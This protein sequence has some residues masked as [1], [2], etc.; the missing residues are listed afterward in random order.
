MQSLDVTSQISARLPSQF[1]ATFLFFSFAKNMEC[2]MQSTS[3][4]TRLVIIIRIIP[5]SATRKCSTPRVWGL[6]RGCWRGGACPGPSLALLTGVHCAA[7]HYYLLRQY[8]LL[9]QSPSPPEVAAIPKTKVMGSATRVYL[10]NYGTSTLS[11]GKRNAL[12]QEKGYFVVHNI[13]QMIRES[14]H[15]LLIDC[16]G[17]DAFHVSIK[18]LY[19]H[20]IH[21]LL[22]LLISRWFQEARI[23]YEF[24][25]RHALLTMH[26]WFLHKRLLS[27]QVDSHLALLVQVHRSSISG[28]QSFF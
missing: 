15:M 25:P 26:V 18:N 2:N 27:D 3:R 19:L 21:A 8:H 11:E 24:R 13:G 4:R 28:R 22:Y 1:L 16:N 23:P 9:M 5:H 12:F 20:S 17:C 6:G 7:S 14:Q 10:A